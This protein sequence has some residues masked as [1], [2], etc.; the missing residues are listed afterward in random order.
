MPLAAVVPVLPLAYLVCQLE[1]CNHASLA[2]VATCRLS[3]T[4]I[5]ALALQSVNNMSM[6]FSSSS[7][8]PLI[9]LKLTSLATPGM[10]S[11][12]VWRNAVASIFSSEACTKRL[13]VDAGDGGFCLTADMRAMLGYYWRLVPVRCS[14]IN[15]YYIGAAMR[16]CEDIRCLRAESR[17]RRRAG[18]EY[19][20]VRN[21]LLR[22]LLG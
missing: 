4:T 15:A 19:L 3:E 5:S 2:R 9:S 8:C 11:H 6:C 12:S 22:V 20:K 7:R 17:T 21:G 1:G 13:F 16:S 10:E 14:S 18:L